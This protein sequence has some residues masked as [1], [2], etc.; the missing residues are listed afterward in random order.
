LKPLVSILIPA[1]NAGSWI[2]ESLRSAV[3]Q[4]WERKEIIVI[5]DGSTDNTLAIARQFES[6]NVNVI[7]QHNQGA[8]ATRNNAFSLAQGDYIQW[9][10][11]DD[12][13]SPEKV[14]LQAE[15]AQTYGARTLISGPF[16]KF[17]YRPR[18]AKFTPTPLWADL[19]PTEW[20]VRKMGLDL[21]MQTATWLVSR[22][23]TQ[24]AGPWNTQLLGDDD[25]EYFCRVLL[26]SEGVRFVH[27]ANVYYRAAGSTSLS[28]I[29][30]SDRKRDAQWR[31]MLLHIQYLRSLEDSPRTREA[32]VAYL[33][34]WLVFFFPDRTDLV[35]QS[36][37]LAATLGGR[38]LPPT[39]SWK[40]AWMQR[41]LGWKFAKRAQVFLRAFRWKCT[42]AWDKL[43]LRW[44]F[45]RLPGDHIRY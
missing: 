43:A 15:V 42:S 5:N 41:T 13:L 16:A 25:G 12:L 20:L 34:N 32:C 11:A 14:E 45:L 19:S 44:E 30:N 10:D 28:Y 3:S 7:T 23:L 22:E 17:L 18:L 26:Q 6:G 9:L 24:A 1:Y 21:H 4:T 8:A 33:Q 31:S 40:Y 27:G 29:G 38:I 37:E 36:K 2:H 39:L 35:K